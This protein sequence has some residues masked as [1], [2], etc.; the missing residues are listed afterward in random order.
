MLLSH[1]GVEVNIALLAIAAGLWS[2]GPPKNRFSAHRLIRTIDQL[3]MQ[4]IST[5]L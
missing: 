2:Q 4:V 1:T 5:D 3:L